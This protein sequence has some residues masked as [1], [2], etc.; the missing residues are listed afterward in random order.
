MAKHSIE[1]VLHEFVGLL[2]EGAMV[3]GDVGDLDAVTAA[4]EK[5]KTTLE[6]EY[7]NKARTTSI[8]SDQPQ[9]AG[10]ESAEPPLDDTVPGL[11]ASILDTLGFSMTRG[12]NSCVP[13][14][15][16]FQSLC[17]ERRLYYGHMHTVLTHAIRE[18][19]AVRNKPDCLR[20]LTEFISHLVNVVKVDL[21]KP[22]T[23]VETNKHT[24]PARLS[25]SLALSDITDIISKSLAVRG[26]AVEETGPSPDEVSRW[27]GILAEVLVSD[28]S[29]A[30]K[31]RRP[32][33]VTETLRLGSAHNAMDASAGEVQG[34][35]NCAASMCGNNESHHVGKGQ[36]YK[37]FDADDEDDYPLLQYHL[38][39]ATEFLQRAEKDGKT[40]LVHCY[41]GVN[42]AATITI[43]YLVQTHRYPLMKAIRLV[44]SK[45]P[46]ILQ[47][48]SFREQL[49]ILAYDEGLLQ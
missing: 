34:I 39:E 35:L 36:I 3:A 18:A 25:E 2:G 11:Q 31:T 10:D 29:D 40:V 16:S 4:L 44:H 17:S 41:A 45:R 30:E 14:D 27:M 13:G 26:E 6:N 43:A 22:C 9:A 12:R 47:N 28:W 7:V 49:I 48:K 42:R 46:I 15:N 24:S 37:H 19:F 20:E 38:A 32:A 8:V 21:N 23:A 5:R 33:E 1:D